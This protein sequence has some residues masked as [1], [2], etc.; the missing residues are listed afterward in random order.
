MKILKNLKMF[1]N[2]PKPLP[3]PS[4][5]PPGP[6]GRPG[7]GLCWPYILQWDPNHKIC[8]QDLTPSGSKLGANN[9]EQGG[10]QIKCKNMKKIFILLT[11]AKTYGGSLSNL[12]KSV[13]MTS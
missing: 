7:G 9:G 2:R 11:V 1:R 12:A 6:P 10:E 3:N 4:P 8:I 13:I 5:G